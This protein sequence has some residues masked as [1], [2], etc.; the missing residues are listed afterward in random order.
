MSAYLDRPGRQIASALRHAQAFGFN[1]NPK[2]EMLATSSLA[3]DPRNARR[4][5][6]KQ[7][8]QLVANIRRFGFAI[9]ILV[10]QDQ[11]IVAGHGRWEAAKKLEL[12]EVPVIRRRF[13]DPAERR[14]FALADN[15]L[16]ELSSWDPEILAGELE[17]L[18]DGGF[19]IETIGFSTADLD[20]AIVDEKADSAKR[21]KA[22]R[23]ELPDPDAHAVSRAGD[24]WLI[25]P[26]K[27][28]CGD[29]R[30]V[31]SW[32]ALLAEDRASLV[33]ADPPFNVSINGHVSGTGH[34]REFVMG[35][36]EMSAPEFTTFL[37]AVFRNCVR[38][39][40]DGS[41]HYHCM[42]WRHAREILDAADG[43]YDQFKQLVVWAKTN[44]S[45]GT[46]YRSR[47]EL[48]FVFKAG[49][50]KHTNNFG[51]GETGR[52]RTNVVEYAGANTFRKG[53]AEDLEAHS[54]V[55]PTAMVAD[56]LLDCSN[57]GDLVVDPFVGSGTTL[58]A[59]HRTKRR[60]SGIE[61]DPL[62]VDTA[63][64]RL[65]KASGL[66]PI[67]AGDGRSFDEIAVARASHGEV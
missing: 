9:P 36:G 21:E 59:A 29:A 13:L 32:E 42:D 19:D 54:T 53:R 37:R 47:H 3:A 4:H 6:D 63:L 41:I 34:H 51:L 16:A 25:G 11:M 66:T 15:R 49:R 26:H 27:L 31:A 30:Q 2:V 7:I 20:F 44:A 45:M 62:Y 1:D 65:A 40:T 10:D 55:K 12:A 24:L 48:V 39:S 67:L 22:E 61:L 64:R 8:A 43:V 33:F 56:F 58:I 17:I 38:F 52:Y 28:L 46:F 5:P 18:F 60:G 50:A 14:A 57:R 35:A 23:V